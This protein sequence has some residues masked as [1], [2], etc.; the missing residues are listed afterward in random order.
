MNAIMTTG[1]NALT[2]TS[3]ESAIQ[4]AEMMARGK[5]VPSHLHNS[6]GDCLMVIEAS[7]RWQMSPF[8]VAQCTSVI[9]GKLMFE[10]KLVAAALNASGI[11]SSRLDYEFSGAGQQRAVI[12][13]GT[14][15]GETKPREVTVFLADAKTS[16]SLWT[17][18]PDQQLVY[19]G[20]RVWAR[21]H[22]P[23]VML[24]VYAPEEFDRAEPFTGPTI[25]AEAPS[26]ARQ[27]I[28]DAAPLRSVAARRTG[29][30]RSA[31]GEDADRAEAAER[32]RA[33]AAATPR[34]PR[35]ADPE[36]YDAPDPRW[37]NPTTE[38]PQRTDEQWEVWVA[39]LRAACAVMKHRQE[40]VEIGN[41]PSVGDA[42]RDAPDRFKRDIDAILAEA[43]ERFPAEPGDDLDEVA[44][45]GEHNLAAG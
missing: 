21:R 15:R 39:K 6:P 18:Q 19:A 34:A 26:A 2:P 13:R 30:W 16:N 3:M 9:Q 8:A 7:M 40:V 36:V 29:T 32:E 14:L 25:D 12:V 43:F 37:D 1:N 22:A 31:E 17:K 27:A 44:I 5:L 24:G 28:N 11:L 20:T 10:G 23:E 35:K 42:I 38:K 41:K 33:V 45:A 4:L